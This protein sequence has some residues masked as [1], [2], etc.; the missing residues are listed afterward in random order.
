MDPR[1]VIAETLEMLKK[2]GLKSDDYM[3]EINECEGPDDAIAISYQ[4]QAVAED[5]LEEDED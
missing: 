2:A 3:K 5:E 4:W 1:F